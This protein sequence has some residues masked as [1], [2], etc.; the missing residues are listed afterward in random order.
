MVQGSGNRVTCQVVTQAAQISVTPL[1]PS[2]RGS[3]APLACTCDGKL[4]L[5][6]SGIDARWSALPCPMHHVCWELALDGVNHASVGTTPC[7][8]HG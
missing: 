7:D 5:M 2:K 1:R 8:Q 4:L 6:Q 3:R